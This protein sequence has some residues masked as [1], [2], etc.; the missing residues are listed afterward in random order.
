MPAHCADLPAAGAGHHRQPEQQSPV[1][2]GGPRLAEQSGGFLGGRRVGLDRCRGGRLGQLSGVHRDL[3]PPGR[4]AQSGAEN[5]VDLPD[6]AAAQRPADMAGA[7]PA[8][9]GRPAALQTRVP[10][11]KHLGVELRGP[12]R[13]EGRGDVDPDQVVVPIPG[14][15]LEPGHLEPLLDRLPDGQVGLRLPVLVDPGLQPGEH[16]LGGLV[17]L[18]RLPLVPLLA[19]QRVLA[20]VHDRLEAPRARGCA[21][22]A[23]LRHEG[24]AST[25]PCTKPC[26]NRAMDNSD[27]PF[28]RPDDVPPTGFEPDGCGGRLVIEASF[29]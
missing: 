15:V 27:P 25:D 10:A 29:R 8:V 23:T 21:R 11:F 9:A 20:G 2:V 6:G 14:G 17:G 22:G 5:E 3:A 1:R 12:H 18:R 19:R 28:G 26:T 16:D 4:A 13:T 7:A 24:D